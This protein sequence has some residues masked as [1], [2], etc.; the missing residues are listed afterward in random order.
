MA[1]EGLDYALKIEKKKQRDNTAVI[2]DVIY[3]ARKAP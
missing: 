1:N 2:A 3:F